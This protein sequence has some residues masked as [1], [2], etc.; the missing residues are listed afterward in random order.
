MCEN[1]VRSGS[2]EHVKNKQSDKQSLLKITCVSFEEGLEMKG[3]DLNHV[4]V[5][6]FTEI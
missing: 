3:S 6:K 4:Y 2:D 1:W 5:A